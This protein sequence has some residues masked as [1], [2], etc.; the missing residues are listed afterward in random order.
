MSSFFYFFLMKASLSVNCVDQS[1]K[2][3]TLESRML[4]KSCLNKGQGGQV[5]ITV[6][7]TTVVQTT[8]VRTTVLQTTV[9][10]MTVVQIRVVQMTESR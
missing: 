1:H 9:V 3:D 4:G 10:Q 8:V 5:L 6:V 2:N 7:Q